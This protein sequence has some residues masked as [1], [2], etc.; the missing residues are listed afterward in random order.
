M[1][2]LKNTSG[3]TKKLT[4]VFIVCVLMV[5]TAYGQFSVHNFQLGKVLLSSEYMGNISESANTEESM[6]VE[7]WMTDYKSW[8]IN[9]PN[10][11]D[12]FS[13]ENEKSLQV[14]S[15]MLKRFD[16]KADIQMFA[17]PVEENTKVESWMLNLNEWTVAKKCKKGL[18]L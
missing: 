18:G 6:A 3:I 15:W 9:K 1:K 11:N 14:E 8:K 7:S 12:L 16:N 2:T 4:A 17:D 13:E 10:G 5:L